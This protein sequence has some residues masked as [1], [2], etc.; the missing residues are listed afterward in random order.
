VPCAEVF[1]EKLKLNDSRPETAGWRAQ[2]CYGMATLTA[3]SEATKIESTGQGLGSLFQE[4]F[5]VCESSLLGGG[6]SLSFYESFK[7]NFAR[8]SVGKPPR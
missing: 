7:S 4:V 8:F 2:S 3:S 5:R 6:G 1:R